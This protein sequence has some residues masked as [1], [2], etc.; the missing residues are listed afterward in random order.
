MLA[1]LKLFGQDRKYCEGQYQRGDHNIINVTDLWVMKVIKTLRP[2][3]I[4][5]KCWLVGTS[6]KPRKFS[7]PA[8]SQLASKLPESK[9]SRAAGGGNSIES[10]GNSEA[11][12]RR[13]NQEK[14][15]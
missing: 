5:T 10:R 2:A 15:D 4:T 8:A 9:T 6:C 1:K 13:A 14:G 12:W 7:H 3:C 11:D